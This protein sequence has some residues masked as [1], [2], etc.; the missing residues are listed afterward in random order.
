MGGAR[1]SW[2]LFYRDMRNLVGQELVLGKAGSCRLNSIQDNL[3]PKQKL[4]STGA[5]SWEPEVQGR[6]SHRFWPA[7][8]RE[9]PAGNQF[10]AALLSQELLI[11]PN[12]KPPSSPSQMLAPIPHAVPREPPFPD[13]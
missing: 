1:R 2:A 5:T 12:P 3:F 11:P 8:W 9:C 13:N 6:R 10:L 4:N 7:L